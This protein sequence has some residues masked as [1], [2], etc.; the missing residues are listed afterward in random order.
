MASGNPDVR[1]ACAGGLC[2]P[3]SGSTT[4]LADRATLRL[5]APSAAPVESWEG[6]AGRLDDFEATASPAAW[7]TLERYVGV[8]LRAE[9]KEAREQLRREANAVRGIYK[10][11]RTRAELERV[12]DQVTR[13]ADRYLQTEQLVDF[14][15]GACARESTPSSAPN[16]VPATSW[17]SERSR[18]H[19]N[20]WAAL[21]R[22]F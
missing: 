6:A 16:C 17:Q 8:T 18:A 14:Y 15:V 13:L 20:A 2:N 19:C 11:A 4:Q 22:P 3:M 21:F 5:A 7:A 12:A 1:S 10:A 9:L